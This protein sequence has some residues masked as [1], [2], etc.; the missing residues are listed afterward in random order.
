[1]L[2][3]FQSPEAIPVLLGAV[4]CRTGGSFA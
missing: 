2:S 4:C 1:M 3:A